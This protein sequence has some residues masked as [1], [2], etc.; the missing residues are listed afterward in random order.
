MN[1]A[2]L[3]IAV[4]KSVHAEMKVAKVEW[5][6]ELGTAILYVRGSEK[7]WEKMAVELGRLVAKH[8]VPCV[9]IAAHLSTCFDGGGNPHKLFQERRIKEERAFGD[10]VNVDDVQIW[11]F[12]HEP[13][14]PI[15]SALDSLRQAV[16]ADPPPERQQL[17][18]FGRSLFDAFKKVETT[19][20]NEQLSLERHHLLGLYTALRLELQF[21]AQGGIGPDADFAL[22]AKEISERLSQKKLAALE[23]WRGSSARLLQLFGAKPH[24]MDLRLK[25]VAALLEAAPIELPQQAE[26]A[27][28][29]FQQWYS[30]LVDALE[31]LRVSRD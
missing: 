7:A 19:A 9:R 17:A 31:Q 21:A 30:R 26:E 18:E 14:S 13:M 1:E 4:S 8:A 25:E 2:C 28:T 15:W 11:G 10:R 24:E 27:S 6:M 5:P 16:V 22:G 3:I 29:T 12:C 23:Q 20:L